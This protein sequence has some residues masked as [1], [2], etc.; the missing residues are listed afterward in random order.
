MQKATNRAVLQEQKAKLKEQKLDKKAL[1][2][3]N[4]KLITEKKILLTDLKRA[5]AKALDQKNYAEAEQ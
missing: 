3:A 1:I 5:Q 2:D 4:E